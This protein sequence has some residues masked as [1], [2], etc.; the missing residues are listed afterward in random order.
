MS[1]KAEIFQQIGDAIRAHQRFVVLSHMRPDGDALGCQLAMALVLRALGKE[2]VVWNEDGMTEKFLYHPENQLV[3]KPPQDEKH[4]FDVVL[5]LDTATQV[6]LGTPLNSIGSAKLWINIDHHISNPGYGDIVWI[7]STSPATGQILFEL[8]Q[9]QNFPIDKAIAEN[10]YAAISTDTGSFQYPNTTARTYEIAAELVRAGVDVGTINQKMYESHPRRRLELLRE[11][12][13]TTEFS[14]EDR[15]ASFALSQA[16]STRLGVTPD[17]NEGLIDT[18]RAVNT[19]EAAVFFEELTDGKIRISMRSKNP[20]I[21]VSSIATHFGGGG[22]KLAAG[23]RIKGSLSEV[24]KMVLEKV[25]D[26]VRNRA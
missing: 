14:A 2:F 16:A 10:L 15:V 1:S 18:I 13:N 24:R 12:L 22:H 17:D 7:D 26:V 6:R 9:Q 11:L 25:C 20:E 4:D 5:A 21:D 3:T 23:A 8:F 19:V